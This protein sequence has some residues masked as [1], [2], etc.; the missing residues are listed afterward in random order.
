MKKLKRLLIVLAAM[1][2][3]TA[4][5]FGCGETPSADYTNPIAIY[6]PD[7]APALAF[8]KLMDEENKLGKENGVTYT[9]F[10]AQGEGSAS[11]KFLADK[12]TM[13]VLPI[14]DVSLFLN[15]DNYK[16]YRIV[17]ILTHGNLFLIGKEQITTLSDLK[18]KRVSVVNIDKVPGLTFK[19]LLGK[20]GINYNGE[21]DSVTLKGIAGTQVAGEI[22]ANNADFVLVPQPAAAVA[23]A[24][25]KQNFDITVNTFN[26][27]E[28][29]SESGFPQAVLVAKKELCDDTN[30]LKKLE[31]ALKENAEWI[32]EEENGKAKNAEKAVNAVTEHFADDA[33]TT[34]DAGKL[35]L[36]AIKGSNIYYQSV[37]D[38]TTRSFVKDYINNMSAIEASAAKA[39]TDDFFIA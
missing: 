4:A 2:M 3:A 30:F 17:S 36:D 14:T 39:I 24:A 21:G 10:P 34:L 13:A 22:K 16:D 37:N 8:A 9:V 15:D 35:P 12:P 33:T 28:C 26:V 25:L 1:V 23:K 27:N 31:T 6:M 11:D 18:G 32:K 38:S 7:G 5:M 20:N 29:Y 19:Y